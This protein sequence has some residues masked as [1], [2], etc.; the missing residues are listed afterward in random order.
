M[1]RV[2]P[3]ICLIIKQ[4]HLQD[5]IDLGYAELREWNWIPAARAKQLLACSG[6]YLKK[7]RD[8]GLIEYSMDPDGRKI[9]YC[10]KSIE[11]YL[12][13]NRKKRYR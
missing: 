10:K 7:L 12:E 13:S 2:V 6:S 9:L 5:L 4:E 11:A 3:G 1:S 8:H